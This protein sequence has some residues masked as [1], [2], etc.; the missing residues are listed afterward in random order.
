MCLRATRLSSQESDGS[1]VKKDVKKSLGCPHTL[2]QLRLRGS[3]RHHS[4]CFFF[5]LLRSWMNYT[6][7]FWMFRPQILG[8][9]N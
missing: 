3:D 2:L 6:S 8:D 1:E 5:E 9:S 4:E 7:M